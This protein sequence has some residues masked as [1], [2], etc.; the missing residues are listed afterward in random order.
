[1]SIAERLRAEVAE[2]L[3]ED[4]SG[5]DPDENLLEYGMDSVRLMILLERWQGEG[6]D[7]DFA[8][9]VETPTLAG[10]TSLFAVAGPPAMRQPPAT[11]TLGVARIEQLTPRTLRITLAGPEATRFAGAGPADHVLLT[12]PDGAQRPVTAHYHGGSGE[13]DVDVVVH[14]NGPLGRWAAQ[15]SAGESL[16]VTG[17]YP[18]PVIPAAAWSLFVVDLTAL[19][20]AA[21]RVERAPAGTTVVLLAVVPE[22]AEEVLLRTA[23]E[24]TVHWVPVDADLADR[25]AGLDLPA[26]PGAAWTAGSAELTAAASAALAARPEFGDRVLAETYRAT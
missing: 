22:A 13:L 18:A 21:Q 11:A 5:I 1:M 23:A 7:I 10:W 9:L 15:V 12:L 20:A 17:S 24:V 14:D 2:I 8:G 3:E 16:T 4:L 25:I 26:G 6:L 19:P